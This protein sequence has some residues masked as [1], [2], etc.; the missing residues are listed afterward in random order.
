VVLAVREM[1]RPVA[2]V[3]RLRTSRRLWLDDPA[4]EART[5]GTADGRL[6]AYL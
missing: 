6:P 3:R 4:A 2:S 5:F 1:L